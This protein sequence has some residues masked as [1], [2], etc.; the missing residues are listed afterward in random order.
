MHKK[1]NLYLLDANKVS[2]WIV[3][4]MGVTLIIFFLTALRRKFGVLDCRKISPALTFEFSVR[5]SN[6]GERSS[7]CQRYMRYILF[8]D[9]TN[10]SAILNFKPLAI[11]KVPPFSH[12]FSIILKD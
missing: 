2:L 5:K 3:V 1:C 9:D 11:M 10:V 6:S 7:V 8:E 4:P 12:L